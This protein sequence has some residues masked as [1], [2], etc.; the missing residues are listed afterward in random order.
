MRA[1]KA[2]NQIDDIILA[3]MDPHLKLFKEIRREF[4]VAVLSKSRRQMFEIV[5]EGRANTSSTVAACINEIKIHQVANQ[6][7]Q[8]VTSG[9]LTRQDLLSD[10]GVREFVYTAREY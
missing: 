3:G 9:W 7:K 10:K 1:P 2:I 5:K 4:Y 8:L 6:L